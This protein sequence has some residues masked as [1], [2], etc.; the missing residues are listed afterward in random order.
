[1]S[2]LLQGWRPE[3]E[4][5]FSSC[6]DA[7]TAPWTARASLWGLHPSGLTEGTARLP[8]PHGIGEGAQRERDS[9]FSHFVSELKLIEN[10]S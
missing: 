9:P 6:S 7:V 4:A 5:L 2:W 10:A 3:Q 1:M 8:L